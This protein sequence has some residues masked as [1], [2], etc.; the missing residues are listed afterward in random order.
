MNGKNVNKA[1]KNVTACFS[2]KGH[3]FCCCADR[4]HVKRTTSRARRAL[5]KALCR[6]GV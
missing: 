4:R 3:D 6:E 5:D 2:Y 1:L